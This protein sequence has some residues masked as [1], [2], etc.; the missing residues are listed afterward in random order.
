MSLKSIYNSLLSAALYA[1][2]RNH[3]STLSHINKILSSCQ[4]GDG[5]LPWQA[6]DWLALGY[7]ICH[8]YVLVVHIWLVSN[9]WRILLLT[10]ERC[11]QAWLG[12]WPT[13]RLL[14]YLHLMAAKTE[15]RWA[16]RSRKKC[17]TALPFQ[18]SAFTAIDCKGL[19]FSRPRQ[20]V[21]S[22]SPSQTEHNPKLQF[23]IFW[24][25]ITFQIVSLNESLGEN[26]SYVDLNSDSRVRIEKVHILDIEFFHFYQA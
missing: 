8:S 7:I 18:L 2:C 14:I 24:D 16:E 9:K 22:S 3:T 25:N 5:L 15:Q 23:S 12:L 1:S 11:G 10:L 19:H 13:W 26:S 20:S 6:S 21:E 4:Y 17:F